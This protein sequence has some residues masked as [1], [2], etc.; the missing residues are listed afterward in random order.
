MEHSACD[1]PESVLEGA[2]GHRV[3]N[4]VGHKERVHPAAAANNDTGQDQRSRR[5]GQRIRQEAKVSSVPFGE[6]VAENG[7]VGK[8]LHQQEV[9]QQPGSVARIDH[10]DLVTLIAGHQLR[11]GAANVCAKK[12][13]HTGDQCSPSTKGQRRRVKWKQQ[14]Q[15]RLLAVRRASQTGSVVD[16]MDSSRRGS[17]ATRCTTNRIGSAKSVSAAEA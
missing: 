11:I 1:A 7:V 2:A 16:D 9:N 6:R 17:D 13:T 14:G 10:A 3:R 8:Q 15:F 4:V 5:A 12:G